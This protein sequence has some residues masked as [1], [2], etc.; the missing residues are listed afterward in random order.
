MDII[1]KEHTKNGTRYSIVI[2]HGRIAAF[3]TPALREQFDALFLDGVR[4]FV[5]D[6]SSVA[7][8]DSAGLAVLINLLKRTQ[9]DGGDVK[10]IMPKTEGAR[11]ILYLT[12]FDKVFSI[13]ETVDAALQNF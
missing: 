3:H 1:T 10:M 6:L 2:L 8:L 4:H 5:L 11:R 13:E 9:R 7:F 12:R